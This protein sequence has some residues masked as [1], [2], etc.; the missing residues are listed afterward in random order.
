MSGIQDLNII[1][2]HIEI[3]KMQFFQL[4]YKRWNKIKSVVEIIMNL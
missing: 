3:E 1:P 4:D 2:K